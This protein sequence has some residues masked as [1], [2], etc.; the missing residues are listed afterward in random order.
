MTRSRFAAVRFLTLAAMISCLPALAAA[1]Y[2][3]TVFYVAAHEDDWQL[4]MQPNAYY[5]AQRTDVKVVFIYLTAG[6]AGCA[7]GCIQRDGVTPYYLARENG[8]MRA[9]RFVGTRPDGA[10]PNARQSTMVVNGHRIIRRR[11][12]NT[13]SWFLRLPDGNPSGTGYGTTG[14]QS[15]Q[16]LYRGEIGLISDVAGMTTY[17]GWADLVATLERIVRLEAAGSSNVV[18]NVQ[19]PDTTAN[20]NDHS[21]HTHTGTAMLDAITTHSCVNQVKYLDY[22]TG[23]KPVNLSAADIGHEA[24]AWGAT[25]SG[26]I[27]S[28]AEST[29]NGAHNAWIGRNYFSVVRGTGACSF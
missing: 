20:T 2:P 22:V 6:D 23:G 15:L 1:Q 27:D 13:M 24:A 19:D 28:G 16:R 17:F 10:V 18:V 29:Y 7:A 25:V 8:A 26:L 21:D 4:F 14:T 3:H 9:A 12:N 11:Y 5:D